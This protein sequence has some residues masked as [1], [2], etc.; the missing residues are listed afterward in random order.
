M[1]ARLKIIQISAEA[2]L[3]LLGFYLWSWS[4]YFI[5]LF[6][7]LDMF[8]DVIFMHVKAVKIYRY[9][10]EIKDRRS[11]FK[12]GIMAGALWILI[13]FMIHVFIRQVHPDM[14]FLKEIKNFW[15]YK[16]MGIEQGYILLP[17][18]LFAS[19]Q[20]YKMEFIM[21]ARYRTFKMMVIWRDYHKILLIILA[22]TG[23]GAG[24]SA[25]IIF[26]EWAY[27]LTTVIGIAVFKAVQD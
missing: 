6:Y 26:P 21:P 15:K 2:L 1:K 16:D 24:I 25:L 11:W 20:K 7:V 27:V 4:L 14:N 19:Y 5:L 17:L 22:F 8:M 10:N 23:I 3:P 13:V 18:L 12:S 9:T